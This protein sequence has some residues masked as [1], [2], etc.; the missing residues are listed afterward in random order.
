MAGGQVQV[1]GARQLRA[2]LRKAGRDLNDLK[3]AHAQVSA[4]VAAAAKGTA[5]RVSGNLAGSIRGN[6][7]ATSAVIKAG[8]ARVP[9][10]GV[11]HW[12]WPR[13][14]IRAQPFLTDAA[15]STEPRWRLIYLQSVNRIVNTIRGK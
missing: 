6:R 1:Q 5:P 7:A 12:G 9:Y 3:E 15:S 11:I 2:T 13:R 10:A 4:F 14:N 8:G